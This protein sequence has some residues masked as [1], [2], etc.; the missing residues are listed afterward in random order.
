MRVCVYC[1]ASEADGVT[2]NDEH[3]L[4]KMFG[5]FRNSQSLLLKCVCEPCN[6]AFSRDFERDLGRD[7]VEAVLRLLFRVK[8]PDDAR[9][10][11]YSRVTMTY[12]GEGFYKGARVRFAPGE[13]A[14]KLFNVELLPQAV[15]H[16]PKHPEPVALEPHE[17]SADAIAP[18]SRGGAVYLFGSREDVESMVASLKNAGWRGTREDSPPVDAPSGESL[19]RFDYHLDDPVRRAVMKIAFNYLVATAGFDFA[20][21]P[22]FDAV[23]SYVRTGAPSLRHWVQTSWGSMEGDGSRNRYGDGHLIAVHW[24]HT[25]AS[26]VIAQ[27]SFFN[28]ITHHVLLADAAAT[29][30]VI[31]R[32]INAAHFFDLAT[33]EAK[34]L[35]PSRALDLIPFRP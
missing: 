7:S 10:M 25:P 2:F 17:I 33:R 9:E 34:K 23:R 32:D 19:M 26:Q 14:D 12:R 8:N 5:K 18:F 4:P 27:L 3:V 24:M 15:F 6:S 28:R 11:S 16:H 29:E 31:W 30:R 20:S 13:T 21:Q 35:K 22:A 1:R